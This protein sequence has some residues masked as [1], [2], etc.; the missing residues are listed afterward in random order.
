MKHRSID[1]SPPSHSS[2]PISSLPSIPVLPLQIV[3]RTN[4]SFE[5]ASPLA[6]IISSFFQ[7]GFLRAV[8]PHW[9]EICGQLLNGGYYSLLERTDR[10]LM[11][12]QRRV[13]SDSSL[14]YPVAI[15]TNIQ[16]IILL[17]LSLDLD[18]ITRFM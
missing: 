4:F 6:F 5:E 18:F 17:F 8:H 11:K 2:I 7:L 3:L 15:L 13:H 1:I 14:L 9:D 10:M 16:V 12:Y